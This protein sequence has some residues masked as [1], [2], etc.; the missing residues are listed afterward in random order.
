MT[1]AIL[2]VHFKQFKFESSINIYIRIYFVF[3]SDIGLIK[4][5]SPVKFSDIIRPIPLKCTSTSG[6]DVIA[7]GNGLTGDNQKV[8][9]ILQYT[10]LMTLGM[11]NCLQEYPFLKSRNNVICVN[12]DKETLRSICQ[13]DSIDFDFE[14]LNS[15][16]FE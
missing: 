9:Q 1:A 10:E 15:L 16:K 5:P 11:L 8:P 2:L 13:G 7:I 12:G 4:L 6:M 14:Y 3:H